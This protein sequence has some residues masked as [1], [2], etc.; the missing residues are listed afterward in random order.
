MLVV[1]GE[2]DDTYRQIATRLADALPKAELAV[3]PDAGHDPLRDRP[4]PTVEVI[5]GFLD[6]LG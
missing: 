5:S 1:A 4:E 3:I 6:G 2:R